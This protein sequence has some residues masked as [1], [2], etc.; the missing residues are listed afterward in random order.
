MTVLQSAGQ[1]QALDELRH[2]ETYGGPTVVH[3]GDV[4]GNGEIPV[5]VVFDCTSV[6]TADVGLRLRRW[7]RLRI[8]I[9]EYFPFDI[10]RVETPHTRWRGTAHVQF[11]SSVCLYR[12]TSVE[13]NPADG[14]FGF[15]ERVIWWLE[16]AAAGQ[17]DA[18]GEPMHPPVAY[19]WVG[20]GG[21]LVIR[22]S[23]PRVAPTDAPWLGIAL[24]RRTGERFSDVVGWHRLGDGSWGEAV[25]AVAD[26]SAA[27][28]CAAAF[29]LPEPIGFEF[30]YYAGTLTRALSRQGVS[31]EMVLGLI[32]L[33]AMVNDTQQRYPSVGLPLAKAF[34]LYALVGTPSRGIVGS[35]VVTHLAAWRVPGDATPLLTAVTDHIGESASDAEAVGEDVLANARDWV[36]RTP[37]HWTTVYEMR[38]ETTIRRDDGS[39]SGWLAGRSVLVLGA[40]ALGAPIT[41]AC[42]RAGAAAVDVADSGYIHPG[43]IVRQPYD[44]A[45]MGKAKATVLVERLSRIR[46]DLDV[47]PHV[48]DVTT[49]LFG[50]NSGVPPFDLIIDAT[51]DRVVRHVIEARRRVHR[52]DWPA[53]ITVMIGHDARRGIAAVSL[54]G[55]SGAAVDI[56]RRL[57][58]TART[59]ATG[60]LSD[61]VDDFYAD[62]PRHDLFQPEPGCSD[63]TFRGGAADVGALAGELLAGSLGLLVEHSEGGS[64]NAMHAL[65]VRLAEPAAARGGIG[66]QLVSWPDDLVLPDHSGRYEVRIA[67]TVVAEVRA[68]CRRGVRLRGRRIETGGLLLGQVDDAAGIVW[69]DAATGPPPDSLLSADHFEHG[70]L[71]VS[72]VVRTRL[73]KTARTSGF[74]GMW[75]SHPDGAAWPSERDQQGMAE[76]VAPVEGGPRRAVLL[77][78]GGAGDSWTEWLE[79]GREPDFYAHVVDRGASARAVTASSRALKP[80]AG[81]AWPGG[82][83]D[84]ALLLASGGEPRRR[85]RWTHA[86]DRLR[87]AARRR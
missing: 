28:F 75:H 50:P 65:V 26:A 81:A 14:M 32:G 64:S 78:V 40:G 48:G 55:S 43:I 21:S 51:A 20:G 61:V 13:W 6:P 31:Q 37:V 3:V 11:G 85:R 83:V 49:K 42:V 60:R 70:T 30:P 77:I 39:T 41:E 23:A 25:R 17:L 1:R 46:G 57:G 87:P 72:D 33:S 80:A 69:V 4:T 16:R 74:V 52:R 7:E 15:V 27:A 12:S 73:Q 71:G 67:A 59:D 10:P 35:D 84:A 18:V 45:D 8:F 58:V 82:Y 34:P 53:L 9:P 2:I 79:D 62:P 24:L 19:D 76:L 63:A 54:P 22:A 86:L 29:I 68:E 47:T 36:D 44:E 66:P 38:P 56:L 5:D